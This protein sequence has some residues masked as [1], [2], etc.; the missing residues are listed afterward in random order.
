MLKFM[1]EILPR[2][3]LKREEGYIWKRMQEMRECSRQY[4]VS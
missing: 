2:E 3:S 4:A 1:H